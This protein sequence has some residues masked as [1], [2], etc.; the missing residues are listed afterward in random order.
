M[1]PSFDHLTPA[2]ELKMVAKSDSIIV[3]HNG[4]GGFGL[5]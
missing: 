4:T 5:W 3:G 2:I 1:L